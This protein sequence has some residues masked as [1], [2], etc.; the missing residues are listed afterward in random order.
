[1]RAL[2]NLFRASACFAL[3]LVATNTFAQRERFS[4]EK[5]VDK[6]GDTL[7]YNILGPDDDISRSTPLVIFLHG[8]GERG[9]D[10]QAQ[11]K[12]GAM[13]FATDQ[14][15]SLHPAVVI[16]PQCPPGQ[17]WGNFDRGNNGMI[18]NLRSTP[19]TP[20][21]ALRELID[22]VVKNYHV[23]TKRIYITGLSMG[24]IG[25]FDAV[26]RYPDL[27]AAALPVCG[28]GDVSKIGAAAKIPMWICAGSDDPN[29]NNQN[30]VDM[31]LGLRKAGAHP[32]FTLYPQTG[33][34]SWLSVYSDP[35]IMEWLFSQHKQ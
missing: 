34:L 1:M 7:R 27:F 30:S 12:W 17:Q 19:T 22:Q 9:T 26:E 20:M 5:F 2:K 13:A 28:G 29:V 16:V 10:N 6:A 24:G 8:S 35:H 23:D 14:M 4:A 18:G 11:L 31:L 32:G 3:C 25:T 33:H 15:M 21:Q